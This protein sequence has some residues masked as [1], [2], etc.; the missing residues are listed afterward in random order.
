M[1]GNRLNSQVWV[2]AGLKALAKSGFTALKADTL[3]KTLGVSRG[4]FYWH[5]ADVEAFHTAVLQRWCEVAYADIV[6]GVEAVAE[7]RLQ[8]LLSRA[9]EANSQLERSM[10]AWATAEPRART[11]VEA[12]DARRLRYLQNLLI[13]A[14][15]EG[16][17]ALTRARI[18]HWAYLGQVLSPGKLS[19]AALRQFLDELSSLANAKS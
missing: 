10:R 13:D 1:S 19:S 3:S 17:R 15:V 8:A 16:N 2:N 7:D 4:S 6:E 5:F 18:I 14:G 12:V 9:F 11:V